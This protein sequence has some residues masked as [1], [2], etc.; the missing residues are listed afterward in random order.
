MKY[1]VRN[2]DCIPWFMPQGR[3]TTTCDPWKAAEFSKLL[4]SVPQEACRRCLS[5]CISTDYTITSTFT[6]IRKVFTFLR[7]FAFQYNI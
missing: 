3:N 2:L 6:Q 1:A 5:D 7:I 4:E